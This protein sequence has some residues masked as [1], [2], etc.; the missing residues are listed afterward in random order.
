MRWI[1]PCKPGVTGSIP[2]FA[3]LSDETLSMA[4]SPYDLSC[5]WDVKNKHNIGLY[6]EKTKKNCSETTRPGALIFGMQHHIVDLYQICSTSAPHAGI[7][8]LPWGSHVSHRPYIGK[9]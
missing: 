8:A 5:W 9:I 4:Q 6:R 3:S 7:M 1:N 2:G